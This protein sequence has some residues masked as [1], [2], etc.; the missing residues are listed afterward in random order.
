M[1]SHKCDFQMKKQAKMNEL[2]D[3]DDDAIVGGGDPSSCENEGERV[4]I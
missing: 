3:C 2:G 4:A 1:K